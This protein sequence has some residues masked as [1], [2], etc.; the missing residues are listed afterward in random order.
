MD[1][2]QRKPS[3]LAAQ[4]AVESP[5]TDADNGERDVVSGSVSGRE[6]AE[7]RAVDRKLIDGLNLVYGQ[8]ALMRDERRQDRE[9]S[10]EFRQELREERKEFREEFRDGLAKVETRAEQRAREFR[11]ALAKVE[12]RTEQRA[13]DHNARLAA[14]D[15]T[16]RELTARLGTL[17]ERSLGVRRLVWGVLGGLSLLVAG[18]VIRPVFERAVGALFGG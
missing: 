2:P 12:A 9:E 1:R 5:Y 10:R 4:A 17:L 6:T 15:E 16:V 7:V 11:D 18:A 14:S 8:F 3:P 13:E